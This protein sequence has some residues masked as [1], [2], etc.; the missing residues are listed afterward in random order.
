MEWPDH[1]NLSAMS[2][3]DDN[4]TQEVSLNFLQRPSQGNPDKFLHQGNPDK[5]QQLKNEADKLKKSI[6]TNLI[7]NVKDQSQDSTIFEFASAFDLRSRID[8]N[9]HLEYID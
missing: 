4:S 2:V 3:V 1:G 6:A 5:L 8:L 9:K 7:K